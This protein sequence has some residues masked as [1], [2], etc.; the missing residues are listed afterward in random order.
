MFIFSSLSSLRSKKGKYILEKLDELENVIYNHL[1]IHESPKVSPTLSPIQ[2]SGHDH[3][4]FNFNELA[5][6]VYNPFNTK[7]AMG[8]TPRIRRKHPD[9][10]GHIHDASDKQ[11][12]QYLLEYFSL[13][14]MYREILKLVGKVKYTIAQ[15]GHLMHYDRIGITFQSL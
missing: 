12:Y 14:I 2:G 5:T 4:V 11:T 6:K 7:N 9:R 15:L 10:F 3:S 8:N 1:N 13:L